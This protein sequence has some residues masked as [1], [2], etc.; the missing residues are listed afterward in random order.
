MEEHKHTHENIGNIDEFTIGTPSKGGQVAVKVDWS[1]PDE[2][3]LLIQNALNVR[4]IMAKK[5]MKSLE[6][7]DKKR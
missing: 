2:A 7:E 6:E 3:S 1:K 5:H 4:E